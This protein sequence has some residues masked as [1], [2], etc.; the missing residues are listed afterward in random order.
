M[1]DIPLQMES[2]KAGNWQAGVGSTLRGKTLAS[3]ATERC[4]VVAVR[5]PSA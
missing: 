4:A 5:R 3:S 2:L 1:R